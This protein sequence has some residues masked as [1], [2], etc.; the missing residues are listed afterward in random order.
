MPFFNASFYVSSNT[1][2]LFHRLMC[3]PYTLSI[4][5]DIL[6]ILSVIE[7]HNRYRKPTM[8]IPTCIPYMSPRTTKDGCRFEEGSRKIMEATPTLLAMPR[9]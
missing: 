2:Q 8:C 5:D 3:G 1:Q 6:L 9:V 7:M 4:G